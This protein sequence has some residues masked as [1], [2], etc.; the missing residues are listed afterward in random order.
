MKRN[1]KQFPGKNANICK[2]TK[3]VKNIGKVKNNV[4]CRSPRQFG[5]ARRYS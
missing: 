4:A 5:Y 1:K 3:E 2:L